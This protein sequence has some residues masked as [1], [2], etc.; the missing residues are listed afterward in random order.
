MS[1]VFAGITPHPPIIIPEIGAEN[2]KDVQNTIKAMEKLGHE[3]EK[4]APDYIF[5]ISPHGPVFPDQMSVRSASE[6]FGNFSNFGAPEL[7]FNFKGDPETSELVVNESSKAGIAAILLDM[8]ACQNYGLETT[9]DHGA[10]VP[11]YY[12]LKN[13]KEIP[14]VPVAFSYLS[15]EDHFN[16]GKV[17]AQ[18]AEHESIAI[19]ASGDLS[20]SLTYD[21]PAGY[22]PAGKEFDEK[23]IDLLKKNK[24]EEIKNMNPQFIEE[25]GECGFRSILILLGALS[26]QK[27]KPEILSYEGPFGVGYLVANFKIK[28]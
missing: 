1:I 13:L 7:D 12:L 15:L 2:L 22:T 19:I 28:S 3:L 21:A 10:L 9:L 5:I 27:Y 24:V 11:A 14:I 17:L 23:L 26:G 18:I 4:S 25:A 16:F 20:H 8:A 6:Y